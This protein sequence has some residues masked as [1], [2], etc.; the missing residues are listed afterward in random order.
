M[1]FAV[2]YLNIAAYF[3]VIRLDNH[4]SR[5]FDSSKRNLQDH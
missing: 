2:Y 5:V 4:A 1:I 3:C